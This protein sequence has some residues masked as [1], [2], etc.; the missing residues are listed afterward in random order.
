MMQMTGCVGC[1]P[2]GQE[3]AGSIQAFP[4]GVLFQPKLPTIPLSPASVLVRA[5]YEGDQLILRPPRFHEGIIGKAS[6]TMAA[7]AG[8]VLLGALLFR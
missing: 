6:V 2:F 1:G 7:V 8:G 4:G 5:S 3:P